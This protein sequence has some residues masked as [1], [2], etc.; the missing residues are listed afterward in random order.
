MK[1]VGSMPSRLLNVLTSK[2]AWYTLETPDGY[3]KKFQPS[4]WSEIIKSDNEFKE[5][6]IRIMDQEVIQRF[7]RREGTAEDFYEPYEEQE[8]SNE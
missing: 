8:I 4:K 3:S 6:V 5:H 2:G 1:K 7:D